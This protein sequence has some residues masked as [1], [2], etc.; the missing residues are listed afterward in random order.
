LDGFL[1]EGSVSALVGDEARVEAVEAP[2][3]ILELS[4]Q[5]NGTTTRGDEFLIH[6]A[7]EVREEFGEVLGNVIV[8][9]AVKQMRR[10]H[11]LGLSLE[12]E[13]DCMAH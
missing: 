2:L 4:A 13:L 9:A 6:G 7:N 10:R 3:S 1:D 8:A 11:Q 5:L 12:T